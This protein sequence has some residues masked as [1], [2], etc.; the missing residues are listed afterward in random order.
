M[1][2]PGQCVEWWL[3]AGVAAVQGEARGHAAGYRTG[4]GGRGFRSEP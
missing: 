4:A 2:I 3:A 1:K